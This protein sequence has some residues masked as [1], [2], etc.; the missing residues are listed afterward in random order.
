MPAP[1]YLDPAGGIGHHAGSVQTDSYGY[2]SD[3]VFNRTWT[4]DDVAQLAN[5][6]ALWDQSIDQVGSGQ[7]RA[8]LHELRFGGIQLVRESINR[9]V[10][11][12]CATVGDSITFG[13]PLSSEGEGQ[14]GRLPLDGYGIVMS[15]GRQLPEFLT[16]TTQD[17]VL[18][19]FKTSLLIEMCALTNQDA[20]RVNAQLIV[21][22]PVRQFALRKWLKEVFSAV[23]VSHDLRL[24]PSLLKTLRDSILLEFVS[25][26]DA[27]GET[28]SLDPFD[29][30][31][32]I[33]KVRD[34]VMSEQSSPLTVLDVC[35]AVGI[36]RRTLQYCFEQ[37]LGIQPASYL[38]AIRLN[39]VRRE[40]R[41]AEPAST[42]VT[43]VAT[44]WGF[45]HLG[46]FSANYRALF[47]E[48]PS[49]TL[50]K[51]EG[52]NET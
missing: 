27:S 18:V 1:P 45:W 35:I 28:E 9:A 37:T 21:L 5:G 51:G 24:P 47:G 46:R 20:A 17:V 11:K 31:H 22:D 29:R 10:L 44:R 12:R 42:S 7:F 19:V 26:I 32:L 2:H 49:R 14:C 16:P 34:L 8:H 39:S 15:H 4:F 41:N 36:S 43:D 3:A 13:V 38:R 25:M 23:D 48:L 33:Q 40:L 52:K 6:L 50:A 30:C